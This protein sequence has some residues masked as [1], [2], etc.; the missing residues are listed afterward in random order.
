MKRILLIFLASVALL[1]APTDQ[2]Q[3]SVSDDD[4]YVEG[5]GTWPPPYSATVTGS[6]SLWTRNAI[7]TGVYKYDLSLVR[8]N[9]AALPDN[10][11]V[12][13]AALKLY[14][15]TKVTADSREFR[16]E[17]YTAWPID[18]ADYAT[19]P[20]PGNNAHA[21]TAIFAL[22]ADTYN[23]FALIN[24][25][26]ISKTGYTGFRCN[27]SGSTPSGENLV[28]VYSWDAGSNRPVLEVTYTLPSGARVIVVLER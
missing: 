1:F 6:T 28:Q 27:V 4:G 15:Y 2:F 7:D 22:T 10:A 21:G 19:Y 9:T 5:S 12:T 14:V 17:Y 25:G 3:P 20:T 16:C 24:L 11:T 8:F 18:A 13:A 23:S 26:N